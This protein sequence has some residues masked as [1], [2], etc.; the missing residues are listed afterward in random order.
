MTRNESGSGCPT[1]PCGTSPTQQFVGGKFWLHA[2]SGTDLASA[3]PRAPALDGK[4]VADFRDSEDG[5]ASRAFTVDG[6]PALEVLVRVASAGP[7]GV[8][9]ARDI[10]SHLNFAR[11]AFHLMA[12]PLG[13]CVLVLAIV[14][15]AIAPVVARVRRLT[16]DVR[17]AAEEGYAHPVT[18]SGKDEVG[19]LA[20]AFNESAAVIRSRIALVEQREV[21]MR[22]FLDNTTHDVMIPVTVLQGHLVELEKSVGDKQLLRSAIEEVHYI[23]AIVHNLEAAAKLDAGAPHVQM[24]PIRLDQLVERCVERYL[25]IAEKRSISLE[26][27]VPPGAFL[28]DADV[29]LVEQALGTWCTTPSATTPTAR[30]W[31]SSSSPWARAASP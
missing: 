17:R 6:Q 20:V 5:W 31:V 10:G 29:T 1:P 27:A 13:T 30:T 2:Y 19:E 28:V 4:L 25:P 18:V 11:L 12:V 26:F 14:V 16:R 7:C 8:V 21:T 22:A 23:S 15:L 24:H 9:L 3:N